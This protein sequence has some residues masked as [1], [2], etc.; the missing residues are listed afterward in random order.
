MMKEELQ[1]LN[2]L[3]ESMEKSVD[4]LESLIRW[5]DEDIMRRERYI[6]DL[7]DRNIIERI[8]NT[9][10]PLRPYINN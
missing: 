4:S 2:E 5:K 7:E 1:K 8:F 10:P 9:K 3:I 6:K